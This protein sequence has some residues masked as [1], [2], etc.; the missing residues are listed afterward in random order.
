M[1][2]KKRG[3]EPFI[4][5]MTFSKETF[6][7]V[8]KNF[9]KEELLMSKV[10]KS[11][12]AKYDVRDFMYMNFINDDNKLF[13]VIF[14]INIKDNVKERNKLSNFVQEVFECK[15]AKI[16]NKK[17]FNF[18][19]LNLKHGLVKNDILIISKDNKQQVKSK[20]EENN[21]QPRNYVNEQMNNNSN[22]DYNFNNVIGKNLQNNNNNFNNM[23]NNGIYQGQNQNQQ[24]FNNNIRSQENN[25]NGGYLFGAHQN[26]NLEQPG[27]FDNN[28]MKNNEN[29]N[30]E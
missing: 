16:E 25:N 5:T 19:R 10:I 9:L 22:N 27:L 18:D 24:N 8:A 7:E 30:G 6:A 17:D 2:G 23:N 4:V 11:Q 29:G 1:F 26:S 13:I 28:N 12:K 20:F 21:F 3:K 15:D 14:Q